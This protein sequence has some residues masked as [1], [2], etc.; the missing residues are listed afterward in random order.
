M[1][2]TTIDQNRC[3]GCTLC[4]LVCPKKIIVMS[5]DH[6]NAKGYYPAEIT[7]M[8]E[9]IACAQCAIMCPDCAI[10]VER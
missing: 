9:C 8:S 6:L 7:D 4:T 1:A 5:K 3:K 10:T 2:K